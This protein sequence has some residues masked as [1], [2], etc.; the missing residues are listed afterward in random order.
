MGNGREMLE[1]HL[2]G[3]VAIIYLHFELEIPPIHFRF[4][5]GSR[6]LYITPQELE[7]GRGPP[8]M[9]F[10]LYEKRIIYRKRPPCLSEP[11]GYSVLCIRQNSVLSHEAGTPFESLD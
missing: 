2:V 7:I 5:L 3:F 4:S 11:I 8:M 9:L 6:N 10:L 1:K